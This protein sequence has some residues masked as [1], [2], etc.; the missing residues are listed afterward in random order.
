[1]LACTRK[2]ICCS[3]KTM[4]ERMMGSTSSFNNVLEVVDN[5]SNP[6]RNMVIDVV[7][8]NQSYVGQCLIVNEELDAN[9][10]RFCNILKD[11]DEILWDEFAN[12]N[13]L[14]GIAH[15]FT[16]KSDHELSET[17]YDKILEWAKKHFT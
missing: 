10:T 1:M 11:L 16:I 14:L 3:T 13:K 12:H 4:V 5:N 17:G 9:M 6:Y 2:T 7:R 15:V 8:M